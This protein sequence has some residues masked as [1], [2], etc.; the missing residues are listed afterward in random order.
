MRTQRRELE[1]L[2]YSDVATLSAAFSLCGSK[3][4]QTFATDAA[5]LRIKETLEYDLKPTDVHEVR[6][7]AC[8]S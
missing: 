7:D 6:V 3:W 2:V 4:N 5:V 1:D 8:F